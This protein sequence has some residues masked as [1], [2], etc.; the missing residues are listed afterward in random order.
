MSCYA[1]FKWWLLLSQHPHCLRILTSLSCTQRQFRDLNWRSRLF[2][3]RPMELRPHGLTAVLLISG[4]RRLIGM[5]RFLPVHPFQCSTP[6]GI[7]RRQPKSCFGENQL[8]PGSISF[9]LLTTSHPK[10][11]YDLRVRASISLSTN[12][13]LLMA[14]SPGF[15]SYVCY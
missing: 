14:S 1:F 15:G 6:R 3:S 7:T 11:L 8:L 13:T 12:F 10:T 9:S 2:P 5:T 4:I